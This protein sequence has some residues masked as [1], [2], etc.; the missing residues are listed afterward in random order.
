MEYLFTAIIV[1][2]GLILY[3]DIRCRIDEY[4]DRRV[5]MIKELENES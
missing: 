5:K 4:I 1:F 3:W 2:C